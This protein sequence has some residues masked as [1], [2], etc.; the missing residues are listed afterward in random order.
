[1]AVQLSK[2]P[3]HTVFQLVSTMAVVHIESDEDFQTR[4]QA[5]GASKLVVIDFSAEW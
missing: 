5:A 2:K 1:M 3:S 4:F